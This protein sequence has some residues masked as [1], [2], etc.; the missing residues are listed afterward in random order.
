MRPEVF[1]TTLLGTL[2]AYDT[3]KLVAIVA[4]ILMLSSCL[5]ESGALEEMVGSI[6]RMIRDNRVTMGLLPALIG[7]LP[8]PGGALFSAPMI[9]GLADKANLTAEYRTFI[10]YWFRHVWEYSFPLYPGLL[11]SATI[12]HVNLGRLTVHQFPLCV[13]AIVSGTVFGLIRVPKI[14]RKVETGREWW[15]QVGRFLR[16]FWPVLLIVIGIFIVPWSRILPVGAKFDPLMVTLPVTVL[17]FGW[18]RLGFRGFIRAIVKGFDYRL[19]LTVLAV[20]IFKDIIGHSGAVEDLSATFQRWGIPDLALFII[21]PVLM[22]Y[23]TG[24]THTYVSVAFPLLMPFF[25]DPIDL[26]RVQLAYAAGFVGVLLSPVHLCLVLSADYFH[27]DLNKVIRFVV[28]PVAL[29]ALVSL[30]M[31]YLL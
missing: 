4:F 20:L 2:T 8:M 6:C 15:V 26:T 16:G 14:L 5:R 13:A 1:G 28:P 9:E 12:L 10:N 27:A 25:G 18:P 31:Y 19:P 17:L 30:A 29:V 21:L 11:L 24:I 23:L 3:I 7:F 22:G